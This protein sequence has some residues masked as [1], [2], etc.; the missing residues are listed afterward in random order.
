MKNAKVI[1]MT[2]K[3]NKDKFATMVV[4]VDPAVT[5]EML[6]RMS[7]APGK[8]VRTEGSEIMPLFTAMRYSHKM[9]KQ[10]KQGHIW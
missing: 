2:V 3:L 6:Y 1:K 10:M 4:T 9:R 5:P 7:G 8:I